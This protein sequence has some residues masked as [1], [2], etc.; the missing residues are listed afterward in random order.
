MIKRFLPASFKTVHIETFQNNTDQVALEN[1]LRTELISDFQNDG[2]LRISS[3]DDA[4]VILKGEIISYSRHALRYSND[5]SVQEY[6]LNIV[7][8]FK[9]INQETNEIVVKA[10]NF[11][12]N[13]DFFLTGA[14]AIS[15]SS[16]LTDAIDDLSRRILNKIITLW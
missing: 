2:N 15:E 9:F 3:P 16:A 5:E 14:S 6:R 8:N 7:V 11:A 1:K 10:D 13:T 4:D 12:G